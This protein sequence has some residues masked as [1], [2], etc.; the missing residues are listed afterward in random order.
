MMGTV[1]IIVST[2]T[3]TLTH[4]TAITHTYLFHTISSLVKVFLVKSEKEREKVKLVNDAAVAI[5]FFSH[6]TEQ[7]A[8]LFLTNKSILFSWLQLKNQLATHIRSK[9]IKSR[10]T[11][12]H[13]LYLYFFLPLLPSKKTKGKYRHI[14]QKKKKNSQPV[15]FSLSLLYVFIQ[16]YFYYVIFLTQI[17]WKT[18]GVPQTLSCQETIS[19]MATGF[20]MTL[21]LT[22]GFWWAKLYALLWLM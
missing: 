21:Q 5:P 4:S 18:F 6:L 19:H 10:F 8:I 13:S 22:T 7:Y 1:M 2:W 3:F 20:G 17:N 11:A 16:I 9:L 12:L 14:S 15:A